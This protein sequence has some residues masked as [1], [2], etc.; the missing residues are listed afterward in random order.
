RRALSPEIAKLHHGATY[1]ARLICRIGLCVAVPQREQEGRG[2]RGTARSCKLFPSKLNICPER[3]QSP[4]SASRARSARSAPTTPTTG[5][6]TPA[7]SQLGA[8]AA[9]KR[10]SNKQR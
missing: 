7:E 6:M 3:D 8:A 5:P 4:R 9:L 1:N 2:R 10:S